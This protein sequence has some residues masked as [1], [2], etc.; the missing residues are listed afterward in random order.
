MSSRVIP[1]ICALGSATERA[2]CDPTAG[3]FQGVVGTRRAVDAT[4]VVPPRG[5]LLLSPFVFHSPTVT[6]V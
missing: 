4:R 6:D 5:F 3:R 1:G 2:V